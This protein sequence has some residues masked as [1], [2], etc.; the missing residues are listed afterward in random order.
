MSVDSLNDLTRALTAEFPSFSF[1]TQQ[2]NSGRS[3]V[4]EPRPGV[5][6]ALHVVIT[7]DP[8]ELRRTL[9]ADSQVAGA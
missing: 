3:L 7:R 2:T 4:A 5:R 6:S 8:A 1:S 9:A